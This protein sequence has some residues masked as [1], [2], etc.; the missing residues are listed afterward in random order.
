MLLP[1]H[2]PTVLICSGTVKLYRWDKCSTRHH[3]PNPSQLVVS[4]FS[5]TTSAMII[6]HP[7]LVI[8]NPGLCKQ[9]VNLLPCFLGVILPSLVTILDTGFLWGNPPRKGFAAK[10]INS[11]NLWSTVGGEEAHNWHWVVALRK[12]LFENTVRVYQRVWAKGLNR[13]TVNTLGIKTLNAQSQKFI[14]E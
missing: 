6:V 14:H 9:H 3:T 1:V 10:F 13:E 4:E 5:K 2:L 7:Y 8:L 11:T 12:S